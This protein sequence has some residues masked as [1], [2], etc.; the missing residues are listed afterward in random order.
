[1]ADLSESLPKLNPEQRQAIAKLFLRAKQVLSTGNLDYAITLLIDCCKRDPAN[2]PY[3]Q[4]LRKT[5]KLKYKDN[6][7]GK[8]L[9]FFSTWR[10][11]VRMETFAKTRNP[12]K[13]IEAAEEIL[14]HNPW[15]LRAQ[16]VSASAFEQLGLK[17]L[18]LWTLDQ[19][20]SA[21]ANDPS[22]NRHMA[23]L[24][25]ERGQ[26]TQAMG[27][28]KLVAQ[29]LPKDKEAAK[30]ASELAATATIAKGK[31]DQAST[32]DAPS[33]ARKDG[34]SAAHKALADTGDG[35]ITLADQRIAKDA[36]QYLERIEQNPT[37]AGAYLALVQLY[38][39]NDFPDKAREILDRGLKAVG[40]N[41]EMGLESIDL[42][43]DPFRRDLMA[44]NEKLRTDPK[45]AELLAQRNK[46]QKEVDTRELAFYRQ[47]SDRYPTDSVAR[48]EMAVRLY[49]TGQF[50]AAIPELQKVL[51]DPKHK[52]KVYIYLGFCFR[53]RN[54]WRLAQR[55]F[56]DA[57]KHL[58]PAEDSF[59]KE[60]MFQL[61]SGY[62]ENG[63]LPRGIE[64]GCE[65]A[66]LDYAY[67][68]IG[69]LIE[70]WQAKAQKP[71]VELGKKK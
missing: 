31:Y 18:A 66:N 42:D 7:K 49:K 36:A 47:K 16:V 39:R 22:I 11:S 6:K 46:L 38:R 58:S 10:P 13:A 4:E 52:T 62:A 29:K 34:S 21:E 33:P 40:N 43:I 51:A 25:E 71:A 20:R 37:N 53:A 44:I 48:F 12:L 14:K 64:L 17:D 69:T 50:E 30:K 45:N 68:N 28:W 41:F 60:I 26:F 15:H 24:F 8:A 1:V 67:K 19:A 56:E 9:A 5:E 2:I 70:Q 3:R 27:L 59:R 65:L 61:A 63:E 35:A 55:N 54:N 57:M 23:R 32:G